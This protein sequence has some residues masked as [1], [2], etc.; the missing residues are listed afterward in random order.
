MIQF[1]NGG[2]LVQEVSELP[3]LAGARVVFADFETTSGD[4]REKSINPWHYCDILGLA[5]T[6][7]DVRPAWYIPVGHKPHLLYKNLPKEVVYDWWCDII[8]ACERWENA[9]VK[10]DA[11][12]STNYAGVLPECELVDLTTLAKIIDSDRLRYGLKYLS[13]DWLHEDISKYEEALKPYLNKNKD[14]GVIPQ[15]LVGEYACQDVLTARRLSKYI[16]AQKPEEVSTVWNNEIELTTNLFHME[17]TG[18]RVTPDIQLK[19]FMVLN[20]MSEIDAELARLVGRSFRPHVADDCFDVLCNQYGLP[21]LERTDTKNEGNN[22]QGNPSF[23]KSAMLQYSAHPFAPKDVVAGI[24]EYRHLNTLWNFF[25]R[26][27]QELQDEDGIL[28]TSYDQCKRTGRLG[29]S[30]PNAQQLSKAAKELIVPPEGYSFISIDY[31]QIEFRTI[32]HYIQDS[33]AIAAYNK[34]PWT[35]FHQWVAEECR[36]HRKPAK[37]INFLMG[38]GGGRQRLVDQLMTVMELV[39]DLKDQAEKIV[40]PGG[41]AMDIFTSLCKQR[42]EQVY[43][44]YHSTLPGLKRTSYRATNAAKSRGYVRNLMGRRRHLPAERA[45]IAFNTL[46][47]SSAADIQKERTNAVFKLC[48]E[49]GDIIKPIASV[50]DQTL[51]IAPTEVANDPRTLVDL[52]ALMED[53]T[54][55]D[56]LRIPIRC[57]V[58]VSERHWREADSDEKSQK[59]EFDRVKL[60]GGNRLRH[61]VN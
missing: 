26:P 60:A 27:Y 55:K 47:Q 52:V 58:G 15:D 3:K 46:N 56:I 20:R 49:T 45:H 44:T 5:I 21:V 33:A 30:Q 37:T 24:R 11:H 12:V 4:P 29:S 54:L 61:L 18:M 53:T 9:N 14:Y 16:H 17:R 36:V 2:I 35:D 23:S 48:R 28:H 31:S 39:G 50:H 25:L 6:V 59:L 42:A 51:F 40:E 1:P 22:W 43:D 32:V 8:D 19:E 41:N 38:F 57:T 7:D 34:D 10:Y 13:K